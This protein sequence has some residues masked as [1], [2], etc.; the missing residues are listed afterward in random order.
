MNAVVVVVVLI[1]YYF[2]L[3]YSSY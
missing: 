1:L 3:A 2:N